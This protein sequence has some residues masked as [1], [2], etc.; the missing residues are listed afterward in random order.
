MSDIVGGWFCLYEEWY[1]I[2]LSEFVDKFVLKVQKAMCMYQRY[3][4]AA[5][6]NALFLR[7]DQNDLGI[8]FVTQNTVSTG[9]H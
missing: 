7:S 6:L 2:N 9:L 8:L 3:F 4:V 5:I 1:S